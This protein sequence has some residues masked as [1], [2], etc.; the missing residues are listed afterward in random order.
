[1]QEGS[2]ALLLACAENR[3][4]V[5]RVLLLELAAAIEAQDREGRTPL[6]SAVSN[7]NYEIAKLLLQRGA[8]S[9]VRSKV[10]VGSGWVSVWLWFTCVCV[11]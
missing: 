11:C 8:R 10:S 4:E 3:K 9:D 2:T 1:M 6:F 5:A 7:G